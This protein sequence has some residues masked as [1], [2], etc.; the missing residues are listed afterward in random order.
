MVSGLQTFTPVDY[1]EIFCISGHPY[2]ASLRGRRISTT[3]TWPRRTRVIF[4]SRAVHIS[5]F[6]APSQSS[7]SS[8]K[9]LLLGLESLTSGLTP[10]PEFNGLFLRVGRCVLRDIWR[11]EPLNIVPPATRI[12]CMLKTYP[13]HVFLS[14]NSSTAPLST[15]WVRRWSAVLRS[16]VKVVVVSRQFCRYALSSLSRSPL[17]IVKYIYHSSNH[18]EYDYRTGDNS[19][20]PLAGKM[21]RHG[22]VMA[23]IMAAVYYTLA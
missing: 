21:H 9:F 17:F 5:G 14:L 1:Q 6:V 8:T 22:S 3:L 23:N 10:T 19:G 13:L 16:S 20:Y 15:T 4:I 12:I 2:G 18:Q 7:K 11:R